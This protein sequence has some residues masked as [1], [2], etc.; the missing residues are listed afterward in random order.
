MLKRDLYFKKPG[1][2]HSI[3]NKLRIFEVKI[4]FY[5]KENSN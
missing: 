5:L 4:L 2:E 3:S 1:K